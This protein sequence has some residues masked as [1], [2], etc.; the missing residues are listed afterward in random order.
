MRETDYKAHKLVYVYILI[1]IIFLKIM[2]R[3]CNVP[4]VY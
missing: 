3:S 2:Q 4:Q 1:E